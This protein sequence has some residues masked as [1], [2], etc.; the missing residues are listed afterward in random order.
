MKLEVFKNAGF[1]IRGGLI[2]GEPYFVAMDIA[3]ALGY[4]DAYS[5]TRR[6]E[7]DEVQ[8][9]QIGGFG[10]RGVNVINESGLYNAILG[11]EKQEAKQFKKWVTSEVLPAIRKHGGYLTTETIEKALQDPDTLITLLTQLKAEKAEKE[12]AKAE[13]DRAIEVVESQ[14]HI[15]SFAKRVGSC[16]GTL[17]IQDFAKVMSD[18][19][20]Y[21]IG[22]KRLF[23]ALR[24]NGYL[25]KDNKPYQKFLD[26]KIFEVKED[27]YK[28]PS[29]GEQVMY[30]KT[31][32]TAK[33]QEYLI[34]R[35][36]EILEKQTA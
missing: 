2:N 10:N 14:K 9:L 12:I 28:N 21:I 26:M 20:H 8:N 25:M 7:D 13:R 35:L 22:E 31:R 17:S 18:K 15:V 4:V 24:E 23:K 19:H 1:E 33:G 11:S 3:K 32:V 34:A 16:L 6:L 30:L 36:D 5:M 27:T 29:T